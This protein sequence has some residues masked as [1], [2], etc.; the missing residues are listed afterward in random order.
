MGILKGS[1]P[2]GG[3]EVVEL[4]FMEN[5]S[6]VLDL[7]AFLDRLERAQDGDGLADARVR[8]LRGALQVLASGTP[9][10]VGRV[11]AALGA[12]AWGLEDADG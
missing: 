3:R 9:D 11:Q 4:Y 8:A 12:P 2:L 6:R 1:C 7:A 5:C 10:K